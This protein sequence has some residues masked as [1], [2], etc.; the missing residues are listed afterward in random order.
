MKWILP[1]LFLGSGVVY[2]QIHKVV[3]FPKYRRNGDTSYY[4]K[5]NLQLVKQLQLKALESS[6]DKFV[7]RFWSDSQAV[8]V[9][10]DGQ[11][12]G[13]MVNYVYTYEEDDWK[14]DYQKRKTIYSKRSISPHQAVTILNK[15][16]ALGLFALPTD[17]S[18]GR[19]KQGVDGTTYKMEFS[20]PHAYHFKTYWTPRVQDSIPEAVSLLA[21][22]D[23][24]D[25][26]LNLKQ[27][28]DAFIA[29]L[30]KGKYTWGGI[31]YL[32]IKK[33]KKKNR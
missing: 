30:D 23:F 15:A 1:F 10:Q 7:F 3:S 31:A 32:E 21:F 18:I 29:S 26:E 11:V 25:K 20:T 27:E 12:K 24:L 8:E 4:Y 6:G 5:S 2:G 16:R 33:R 13:Q 14:N 19:W 28:Q 9:E 17:D 22:I